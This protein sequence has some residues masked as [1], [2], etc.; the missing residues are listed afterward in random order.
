MNSKEK[1]LYYCLEFKGELADL[2]KELDFEEN[3]KYGTLAYIGANYS[4]DLANIG[5]E[6]CY[7]SWF[8]LANGSFEEVKDS[9]IKTIMENEKLDNFRTIGELKDIESRLLKAKENK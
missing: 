3:E 2:Q 9:F 7:A 6:L 8:F 5:F 4:Y 1:F